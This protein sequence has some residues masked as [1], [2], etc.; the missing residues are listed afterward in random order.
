MTG[1]D[2][3]KEMDERRARKNST[4]LFYMAISMI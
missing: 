2:D 3:D 1:K 4:F